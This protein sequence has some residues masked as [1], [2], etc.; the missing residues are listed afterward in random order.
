[1][2]FYS[3]FSPGSKYSYDPGYEIWI[4]EYSQEKMFLYGF[5]GIVAGILEIVIPRKV[6]FV[7]AKVILSWL[8]WDPKVLD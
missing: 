2:H 3:L 8:V 1:M 6:P 7:H 5:S 4:S